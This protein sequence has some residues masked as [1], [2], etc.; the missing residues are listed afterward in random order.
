MIEIFKPTTKKERTITIDKNLVFRQVDAMSYKFGEVASAS[1][2]VADK[3]QSDSAE[4]LDGMILSPMLALRASVLK[5][6][7]KFCL[8]PVVDGSGDNTN[9]LEDKIVFKLVLPA[10]FDDNDLDGTAILIHEYLVRGVLADWYSS[11]GTDLKNSY[12]SDAQILENQIIDAL[13]EPVVVQHHALPY[14][15]SPKHR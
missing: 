9:L 6:R 12:A 5:K 1:P 14:Y 7:L 2:D 4:S 3:V 8:A 15:P 11:I 10:S 13:R